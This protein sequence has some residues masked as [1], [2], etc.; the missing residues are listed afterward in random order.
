M[1]NP[2]R[3]EFFRTAS[4]Y[5]G[6]MLV[7]P[8]LALAEDLPS[9]PSDAEL[10]AKAKVKD[11]SNGINL[12]YDINITSWI[13]DAKGSAGLYLEEEKSSFFVN[14]MKGSIT[15]E[16]EKQPQKTVYKE[17][18]YGRNNI[19]VKNDGRFILVD[20]ES[21]PILSKD[22]K[23][24]LFQTELDDVLTKIG[25][26]FKEPTDYIR[27]FFDGER[28]ELFPRLSGKGN[29]FRISMAINDGSI[30]FDSMEV[31]FVKNGNVS[32]PY[33]FKITGVAYIIVPFEAV[34]FIK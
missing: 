1:D 8:S 4:L 24:I 21:N 20:K 17:G 5:L 9:V 11:F 14:T 16:L 26:Y 13:K 7:A 15:A 10:I 30:G 31:D 6:G 29:L 3:R 33:K 34:G 32:I 25:R 28:K 2:S 19:Y 12:E 27:I 23:E 22:T 18:I